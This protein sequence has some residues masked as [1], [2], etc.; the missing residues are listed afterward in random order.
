MTQYNTLNLK[1]SNSQFN[2]LKSSIKN[3]TEVTLNL[4]SN[5]IENSNDETNFLHKLL[6]TN[7]Q[8]SKIRKVFTKCSSA[9]IKFSKTQL[10]KMTQSGG[11]LAGL[12]NFIEFP[13]NLLNSYE[14][15]LSN[16]DAKKLNKNNFIDAG[17]FDW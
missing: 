6:L 2:K 14:K 13:F 16:I 7:T 9:N 11:I 12:D 17:Q 4:S 10:S 5:L 3:G 1:L 8:V 15:E